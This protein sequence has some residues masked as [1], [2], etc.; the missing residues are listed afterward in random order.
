VSV[1][2]AL[3]KLEA[4]DNLAA[5]IEAD[6]FAPLPIEVDHAVVAGALPQHHDD[7]FD[8]ILVAQAQLERL[9]IVTA[10]AHISAYDVDVLPASGPA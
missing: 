5:E 7:P 3:G 8:R 9:A 4:P 10:D 1:K 2:R 6:G